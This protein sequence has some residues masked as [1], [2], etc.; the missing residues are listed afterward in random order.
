MTA[1]VLLTLFL[2]IHYSLWSKFPLWYHVFFLASLVP[3][4]LFGAVLYRR[5][6]ATKGIRREGS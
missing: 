4:M 3:A 6:V 2:P 1:G 5:L